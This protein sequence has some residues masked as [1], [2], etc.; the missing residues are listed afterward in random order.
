M[1]T[2]RLSTTAH[3]TAP[4]T[5]P[6]RCF[7]QIRTTP[8]ITRGRLHDD[9]GISQPTVTRH[10]SALIDSGLVEQ[11]S[12]TTAGGVGRPGSTLRPDG[13]AITALGAHVGLRSTQL[14]AVDGVGRPLRKR[15]LRLP[16]SDL[17]PD[18]AMEAVHHALSSL[19]RGLPSPVG[20]GIAFSAHV[21]YAGRITSPSYGWT[22][23][24]PVSYLD[25]EIP[26]AV[27]TG[28]GAM[29]GS[30]LTS[31][32]LSLERDPLASTLY[33]YARELV[34]HAWI[35]GNAVHQPYTG[36]APTAF[37]DI[38]GSGSFSARHGHPLGSTAVL[39]TARQ[40]GLNVSTVPDLVGLAELNPVARGILDERAEL[41]SQ[42]ISLA[43]DVVDPSTVVFAGETFTADPGTVRIIAEG[44]RGT[45]RQL[46]IQRAGDGIL[47]RA[48][49]VTAL[50]QL[51]Q[52]PLGV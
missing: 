48:A 51:W 45:G 39:E 8:G 38:A 37:N 20:L 41:L 12:P 33:V 31:S 5:G 36:S 35:V 46:S 3:F 22:D 1:T 49:A 2:A 44:L 40:R 24:D 26:V 9:L 10:V 42:I 30:E 52:D 13:R 43:V 7:H 11:V 27:S 14:V 16:V 29:A 25:T 23:V 18:D 21:D 47:S 4:V 17:T 6:A 50:H 19:G 15:T 28:V 32:P 34:G